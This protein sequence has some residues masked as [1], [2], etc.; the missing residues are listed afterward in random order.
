M[1]RGAR[2]N[3]YEIAIPYTEEDEL[4]R[5][6]EDLQQE[7]SWKADLRHCFAE[8]IMQEIGSERQR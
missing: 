8:A 3:E 5:I 4:N 1:K 6:I 7:I 2:A